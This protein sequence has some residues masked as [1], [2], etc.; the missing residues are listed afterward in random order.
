MRLA[1]KREVRFRAWLQRAETRQLKWP[2]L[3]TL[4]RKSLLYI[5]DV[6]SDLAR[7]PKRANAITADVT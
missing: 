4:I 6:Q 1:K 2:L 7:T 3:A 5:D